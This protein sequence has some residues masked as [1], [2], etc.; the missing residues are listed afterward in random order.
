MLL[1]HHYSFRKI[2]FQLW[3]PGFSIKYEIVLSPRRARGES[4]MPAKRDCSAFGI[5]LSP[6]EAR[7]GTGPA[8]GVAARSVTVTALPPGSGARRVGAANPPRLRPG[9]HGQQLEGC[10]PSPPTAT[11]HAGEVAGAT[12]CPLQSLVY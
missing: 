11:A 6:S 7:A 1:F 4:W 2:Y 9:L 3:H 10:K 12:V 5:Q 8:P